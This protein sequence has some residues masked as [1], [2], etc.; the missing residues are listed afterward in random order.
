DEMYTQYK[1][2]RGRKDHW[3]SYPAP[4]KI[5][6]VYEPV[7]GE[8]LAKGK[9]SARQIAKTVLVRGLP[10]GLVPLSAAERAVAIRRLAAM[11]RQRAMTKGGV[12]DDDY[13][14]LKLALA[15]TPP[16]N[17]EGAGE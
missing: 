17:S 1:V 4:A 13:F 15:G 11:A 8:P 16:S 10:G 2:D 9:P 7:D 14:G 12:S 6:V 3:A 5:K